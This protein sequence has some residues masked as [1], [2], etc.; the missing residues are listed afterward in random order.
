MKQKLQKKK[1]IF[2]QESHQIIYH[3]TFVEFE[4]PSSSGRGFTYFP[5]TCCRCRFLIRFCFSILFC[6]LFSFSLCRKLRSLSYTPCQNTSP[7]DGHNQCSLVGLESDNSAKS[8][9]ML[10]S[11]VYEN[12]L[13][14]IC[15]LR[16]LKLCCSCIRPVSGFTYTNLLALWYAHTFTRS[17]RSRE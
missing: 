11:V 7:V 1:R 3:D 14:H 13:I 4:P 15:P 12:H 6:F 8:S 16:L 10:F 17:S 2:N 9:S 5:I